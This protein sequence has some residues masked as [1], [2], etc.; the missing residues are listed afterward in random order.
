MRARTLLALLLFPADLCAGDTW[1]GW[2]GPTGLGITDEKDLP[3]TW[4][5]KSNDNVRWKALLPGSSGAKLD[6]NQSS[7]IVWKDRVFLIM[8]YWPK[9]V[10]TADYPESKLY[11]FHAW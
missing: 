5:G 1:P 2:R 10:P 8:V 4:G 7:P 9:G 3:L 6:H 11:S